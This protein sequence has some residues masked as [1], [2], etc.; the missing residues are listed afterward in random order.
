MR[1][2][3]FLQP[4]DA[5]GGRARDRVPTKVE[6]AAPPNTG[7]ITMTAAT[8]LKILILDTETNGLP[9]ARDAPAYRHEL[10]PALLEVSWAIYSI[11]NKVMT[12]IE[13]AD[14]KV[15]L[16]A[17]T[18]WDAGAAAIHGISED[19][20]RNTG[21]PA[22]LVLLEL[23]S[24][25]R[26]VQVVCAHN[27]SFDK[28]VLCA[29]AYRCADTGG[30]EMLRRF[31]PA[32]IQEFCTMRTT[33]PMVRLPS[34]TIEGALKAPRLGELYQW[35]YGHRYDISGSFFHNSRSDTHCLI[36]CV[37]GLLRKG[38]LSVGD[39]RLRVVDVDVVGVSV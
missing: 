5:A 37:Q 2:G 28:A 33:K 1:R 19:V 32:S 36:Q 12:L 26:S 34:P 9:K 29:A 7:T 20:A 14:H 24:K 27:L 8:P 13:K 38:N 18:T 25:I 15:Q 22:T 30:P 3:G 23:F 31:W 11:T 16:E 17:N 39:G 21:T 4:R 6:V 10:Y 35:L